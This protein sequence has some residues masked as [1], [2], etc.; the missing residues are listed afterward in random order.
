MEDYVHRVGRTGRAGNKGT[1]YTFITPDQDRYAM[2]ICKALKLSGQE[3]PA[4][5][6]TLADHFQEKVK[7]GKER[8]ASSGFGGKGLERLD[9]DRDLVKRIQKRV[10]FLFLL[11]LCYCISLFKSKRRKK[12]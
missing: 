3:P 5:L 12:R 7:E 9:K 2:D 1:A 11:L 4:D 8:M 10:S 6:Q